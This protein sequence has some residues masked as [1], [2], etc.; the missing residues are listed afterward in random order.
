MY[1]TP[2]ST[3]VDSDL[4]SGELGL[5][6]TPQSHR[7]DQYDVADFPVWAADNGCFTLGDRFDLDE[8][9]GWLAG[10][11]LDARRRCLFATAPDVVGDWEATLVRSLPVL[12]LLRAAGFP[13]AIVVQDGATPE[14]VP[15]DE[16]DAVFVGGSTEWKLSPVVGEI[17]DRAIELGKWTHVGRVN[18]IRRMVAASEL[19]AY[20]VDGTLLIYGPEANAPRIRK[21]VVAAYAAC[22]PVEVDADWNV[23]AELPVAEIDDRL[24]LDLDEYEST[25]ERRAA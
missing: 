13:A 12:P 6:I 10:F 17:L 20:S 11:D 1:L 25:L 24:I 2:Y 22:G 19:G 9:L 16:V 21:A 3:V 18:S 7:P 14:S 4:V 5:L 15:W 8:Y 23:Y